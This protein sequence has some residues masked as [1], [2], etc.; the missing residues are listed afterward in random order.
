M[1]LG[2]LAQGEQVDLTFP[3]RARWFAQRYLLTPDSRLAISIFGAW[4][5]ASRSSSDACTWCYHVG[6]KKQA[7]SVQY[8]IRGVP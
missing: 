5:R 8:T 6:M 2:R 1:A 7:R 3:P 4:I